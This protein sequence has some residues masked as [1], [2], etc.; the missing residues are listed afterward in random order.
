M[1]Q[2]KVKDIL[3]I[4]EK[5]APP[6]LAEEWDNTGLAV[7]RV[8]WPVRKVWVA[9]DPLPQVVR[10]ACQQKVDLLI[11]HHPLFFR[12][13][14]RLDLSTP[15]GETIALAI[16]HDLAL[17]SA[18]TNLDKAQGGVNDILA[19]RL[20][21][22]PAGDLAPGIGDAPGL[23]RMAHLAQPCTLEGFITHVKK[24]LDLSWVRATGPKDLT[25]KTIALCS[26]SG[27]S[28]LPEFFSS[29]AQVFITG[30]L[31]YHH[32]RNVEDAGLACIDVG[33]FASEHLVV[34]ALA[35]LIQDKVETQGLDVLT[36]PCSLEQDPFAIY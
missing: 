21:L 2:A 12:P 30:D 11:T 10:Q 22:S 16:K 3:D 15:V 13:L 17:Y 25:V 28:L 24:C 34:K 7:G 29:G 4:V 20:E 26:G 36:E 14:S 33:H 9:L 23:G 35:R 27:S 18:H 19:K 32:A 8:D 6:S 31:G 5:T 1:A